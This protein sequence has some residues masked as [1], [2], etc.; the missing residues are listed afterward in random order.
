[1]TFAP[2]RRAALT[3][4][5]A[6]FF[7]P[8]TAFAQGAG[9]RSAA[10][11]DAELQAAI[12]KSNAYTALMNRTLRAIESWQRYR[13]WVNI[14]QGPTGRERYISYGLYSLY[15]VRSEL[16]KAEAATAQE[17][18]IPDL[19]DAMR[20]YIQSY[21]ELAPLIA[22]ANGYYERKD[23]EDD[24]MALGRELH[25]QMVPAAEAFLKDRTD[26]EAAMK[27]F[28]TDLNRRELAGI[29]RREGRSSR[30]HVRNVLIAARGVMDL[31]PSNESPRVDLAAFDGA[32]AAYAAALREMDKLKETDPDGASILDS[33]ASS[34]LG[35]LREYRQKLARANGDGR[36]AAGHESMW[37]VNNYNMMVSMSESRLRMRR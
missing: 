6:G 13:S 25:R 21:R 16:E 34:W 32:I 27:V 8:V 33:Q 2:S 17:P 37:I 36:R 7:I 24:R 15:D 3:L 29:E 26:V 1:M 4:A 31:M 28:R 14:Q 22:R 9:T 5:S 30:W 19:D 11:P 18:A 20:R 23:Y 10:A 12:A 35:S